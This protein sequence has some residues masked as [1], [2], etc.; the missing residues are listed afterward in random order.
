MM[1]AILAFA[2]S[3]FVSWLIGV[4]VAVHH[5]VML[6]AGLIA[7]VVGATG[8]ALVL[9]AAFVFSRSARS[10]QNAFTYPLYLLGGV[11]VPVS[12]LPDWVQPLSKL[13]YVSW[14][15]D[16]LRESLAPV[17]VEGGAVRVIILM[18]LGVVWYW[19]GAELL[20]RAVLRLRRHGSATN[21]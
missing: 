16:L 17:S 4:E 1:I 6:V 7:T 13:V 18:L 12:L 14:S 11:I 10:F 2:E 8:T 20:E 9:S 19:A 21:W 3:I 15:G 5:G